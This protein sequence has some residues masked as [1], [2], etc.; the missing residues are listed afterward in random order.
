ML[1]S[2]MGAI[3]SQGFFVV[4]REV[5]FG[6]MSMRRWKWSA[7]VLL[8]DVMRFTIRVIAMAEV[9]LHL[10]EI[11][12]LLSDCFVVYPVRIEHYLHDGGVCDGVMSSRAEHDTI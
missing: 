11:M 10:L 1:H 12:D 3:T 4:R 7:H 8:H 6:Q 9:L 2:E 5:L